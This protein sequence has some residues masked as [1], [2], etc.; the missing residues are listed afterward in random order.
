MICWSYLRLELMLINAKSDSGC[1][2][3]STMLVGDTWLNSRRKPHPHV[4][5]FHPMYWQNIGRGGILSGFKKTA[6]ERVAEHD[7]SMIKL[8]REMGARE[9][10]S[11]CFRIIKTHKASDAGS[12]AECFI[13]ASMKGLKSQTRTATTLST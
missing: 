8:A 6:L 4:P 3:T 1:T 13:S 7:D 10:D 2:P 5:V 11:D 9:S 12:A